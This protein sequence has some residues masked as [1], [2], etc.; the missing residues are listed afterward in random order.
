MQST[1]DIGLSSARS[2]GQTA[3]QTKTQ[4]SLNEKHQAAQLKTQNQLN[5]KHDSIRFKS[6]IFQ[7]RPPSMQKIEIFIQ[8]QPALRHHLSQYTVDGKYV[9]STS[10][11]DY[12][13]QK[14]SD[15]VL[16][17]TYDVSRLN[18]IRVSEQHIHMT[19]EKQ[20]EQ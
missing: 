5:P 18:D 10:E 4:K 2:R 1:L 19:Y 3:R 13:Y 7:N 12:N 14:L 17:F 20:I 11:P 9:E 6:A 16:R 8:K 15:S